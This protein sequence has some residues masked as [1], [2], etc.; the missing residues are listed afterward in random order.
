MD[1]TTEDQAIVRVLDN[2]RSQ[3]PGIPSE[4]IEALVAEI[5]ARY[6]DCRI[7]DFVPL[8]VER[9]AR[10]QLHAGSGGSAI[11]SSADPAPPTVAQGR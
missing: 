8:F 4:H 2:L 6:I 3:F 11:R 1:G 10:A 9:H 7:R 5:H